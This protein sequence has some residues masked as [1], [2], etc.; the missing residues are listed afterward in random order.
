MLSSIEFLPLGNSAYGK[1]SIFESPTGVIGRIRPFVVPV[2]RS[3]FL[4]L[5][6]YGYRGNQALE[7][8]FSN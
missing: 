4:I 3:Q 2:G 8:M 7:K 5:G 6:G 1:W